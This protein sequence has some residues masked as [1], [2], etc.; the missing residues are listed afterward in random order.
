MLNIYE[1]AEKAQRDLNFALPQPKTMDEFTPAYMKRVATL[2]RKTDHTEAEVMELAINSKIFFRA[3]ILPEPGRQGVH[4]KAL[5]AYIKN[6]VPLLTNS[7]MLPKS[8]PNARWFNSGQIAA[9][10][11]KNDTKSIDLQAEI[12][13]KDEIVPVYGIC[14]YTKDGGGAQDN[15]HADV[16]STLKHCTKDQKFLTIALLDGGYYLKPDRNGI[17]KHSAFE[18]AYADY[19]NV[20]ITDY[21]QLNAKLAAW[22]LL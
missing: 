8:G 7:L 2:A 14:K 13:K 11:P 21:H 3:N 18:T 1:A 9:S 15:Q 17:S 10:N 22:L 6:E 19:P 5:D 4:E 16:V 20:L 12:L